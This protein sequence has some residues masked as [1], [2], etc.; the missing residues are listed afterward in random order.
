MRLVDAHHHLWDLE[1]HYYPWLSD[2]LRKTAYGDYSSIRRSYRLEDFR[3]DIGTMPVVK[4]VHIQA[5]FDPEDPVSETEWLQTIA[6]DP[7][8]GGFP[9]GIVCYVDLAK[10]DAIALL[11]RHRQF[12]NVRGVRQMMHYG[13]AADYFRDET[14]RNN[15]SALPQF[16][17]TFDLQFMP[18]QAAEAVAVIAANPTLG[19]ILNHA[20]CPTAASLH[21]TSWNAAIS[22]LA[23]F[24]NLSVKL[25]GFG[26]FDRNWTADSIR[27]LVRHVIRSFGV[28]R[29]MFG[30]NFPVDSL[31]KDYRSVW[32]S[33]HDAVSDFSDPD[34]RLLFAENA[35]R[36]YRI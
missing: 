30:T 21:D 17:L 33:F 19:F 31:M 16:D 24:A 4:S 8:S 32:T 12:P 9:H 36:I 34:Q 26:M 3:A 7:G 5:E 6:N 22:E 2:R 11:T 28:E 27:P 15:L 25:S 29:C 13:A 18:G 35:E 1:A 14:W 10:P 23:H 20:G